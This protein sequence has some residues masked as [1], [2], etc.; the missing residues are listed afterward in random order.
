MDGA[1]F[2]LLT[3]PLPPSPSILARPITSPD[4]IDYELFSSLRIIWGRHSDPEGESIKRD[5]CAPAGKGIHAKAFYFLLGKYREEAYRNRTDD[6]QRDS[7]ITLAGAPIDLE[8]LKFNLDWE[9]ERDISVG[10]RKYQIPQR[11]FSTP[12]GHSA[13]YPPSLSAGPAPG[14]GS[15]KRT[16]TDGSIPTKDRSDSSHGPRLS[17]KAGGDAWLKAQG[18]V[19]RA[20][21]SGIPVSNHTSGRPKSSMGA[22][23]GGPRPFPPRRGFTHSLMGD[24][25]IQKDDGV[26]GTAIGFSQ[27]LQQLQTKT[28]ASVSTQR[29]KSSAV[30]DSAFIESENRPLLSS[31]PATS[32]DHGRPLSPVLSPNSSMVVDN[33]DVH[34][35]LLTAPKIDNPH[36]QRTMDD[37]TQRVNEL[38]QAVTQAPSGL[39][40]D[41]LPIST[42]DP[43]AA[44]RQTLGGHAQ[45]FNDKENQSLDEEGWSHVTAETDRS[46]GLGLGVPVNVNLTLE[47][48]VAR[49]VLM[50]STNHNTAANTLAVAM[51]PS[52]VRKEKDKKARREYYFSPSSGEGSLNHA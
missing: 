13:P 43:K 51:S 37:I 20:S 40:K 16:F 28:A 18:Q 1:T 25:Q 6:G 36:L 47:R 9:T 22:G 50:S 34:L 46:G 39:G 45:I 32:L 42:R 41:I 2:T 24:S 3:P 10:P 31:S 30:L 12:Q 29:P 27:H 17:M 15:R 5:L 33:A 44:T 49:D 4:L 7:Q 23:R 14:I 19:Q 11:V 48:E 52:R 35:P 26:G 21:T 38:V 8:S